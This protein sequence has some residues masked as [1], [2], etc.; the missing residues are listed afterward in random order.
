MGRLEAVR[1]DLRQYAKAASEARLAH[2]PPPPHPI[3]EWRSVQAIVD[4][5][6]I[7]DLVREAVNG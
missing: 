3:D 7:L 6:T 5:N 1:A 4:L 2:E